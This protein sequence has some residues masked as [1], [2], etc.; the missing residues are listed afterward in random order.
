[1]I[2]LNENYR[3][4]QDEYCYSLKERKILKTGKNIGGEVWK[5]LSYHLTVQAALISYRKRRIK[6]LSQADTDIK[7]EEWI[8]N[9]A[10]IT[11][12]YGH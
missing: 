6:T 2:I 5:T 7:I 8:S 9:I 10:E 4:E 1:M 3:I 12:R 11:S